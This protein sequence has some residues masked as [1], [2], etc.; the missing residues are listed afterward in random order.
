MIY[1]WL[2]VTFILP[3][4]VFADVINPEILGETILGEVSSYSAPISNITMIVL[5]AV[6]LIGIII[7]RIASKSLKR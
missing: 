3:T 5:P 7:L 1:I 6:S 2:V 4:R